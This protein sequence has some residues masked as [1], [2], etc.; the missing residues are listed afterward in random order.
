M[1]YEQAVQMY[2]QNQRGAYEPSKE[3]SSKHGNERYS[4]W[5]LRDKQ[6]LLATVDAK[7]GEVN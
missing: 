5:V 4:F 3:L 7:T 1:S 6:G 2:Y